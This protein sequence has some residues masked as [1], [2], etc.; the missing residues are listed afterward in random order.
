MKTCRAGLHQY[1]GKQCP[2]CQSVIKRNWKKKNAARLNR[3]TMAW[4]KANREYRVWFNMV[5]RC[6]KPTWC[7]YEHYGGRGITVC[8]RWLGKHG[9]HNFL[10]DM[11][12][13]PSDR[14]TLER[15]NNMWGYSPSNCMWAT[16][17]QQMRNTRRTVMLTHDGRTMCMKDWAIHLGINPGTMRKRIKAGWPLVKALSSRKYGS[18]TR[19]SAARSRAKG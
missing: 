14:H 9:Y 8:K 4:L 12:K 1:E 3:E 2:E 5:A 7:A 16:R 15:K 11:G 17:H 10:A 19:W 18:T 6:T 13:R